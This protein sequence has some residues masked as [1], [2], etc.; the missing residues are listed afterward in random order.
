MHS[1]AHPPP[2]AIHR[3]AFEGRDDPRLHAIGSIIITVALL[4]L[5]SAISLDLGVALFKLFGGRAFPA[6]GALIA[7]GSFIQCFSLEVG[8]VH[9]SSL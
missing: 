3:L 8:T 7:E 4:P 9:R 6:A 1:A 5:A 2:A